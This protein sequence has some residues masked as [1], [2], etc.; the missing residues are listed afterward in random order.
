M[1][2]K[3]FGCKVNKFFLNQWLN[4]YEKEKISLE[5]TLLIDTCVVTDR[6]KHKRIKEAKDYIAKGGEVLIT[7]CGSLDRWHLI[8][9]E[10]FYQ[11]YPTLLPLKNHIKLLYESPYDDPTSKSFWNFTLKEIKKSLYTKHFVVIQNGCDNH[12]TFCATV[13]KRGIHRNR[14]LQDII[15]EIKMIECQWGKEIVLTGIN[16]AARGC[17][18]TKHPEESQFAVLL[19]EILKQTS[20]P[21]IRISSIGPEY[22][23]DHFFELAS[24]E[25]IMPH[26]HFSIQSFSDKVLKDMKRN[27]SAQQLEEVLTK[28]RNIKRPHQELI[29]LWAD[30]ITGFPG[31]TEEDFQ[32]TLN[33]IETFWITKLHAF[34]FSAH[35]LGEG[36]PAKELANQLPEHIKKER[37]KKLIEKGEEI[38][39]KFLALNKGSTHEVLLEEYRNGKRKGRTDNYIQVEITTDKDQYQKG[40]IISYTL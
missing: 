14:E 31:E 25:R 23:N 37:N 22:L 33:G 18:N 7:W 11:F 4:F 39:T 3:V 16:L 32:I 28:T 9:E 2:Y 24:E 10:K 17:K 19:E 27:Y 15:D 34:P 13:L 6:A 36:I 26:F 20:I 35:T 40:E 29:S 12:C 38:R 5:N 21:R 8:S 30:I 1:P